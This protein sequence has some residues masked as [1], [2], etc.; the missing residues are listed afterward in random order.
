MFEVYCLDAQ[1]GEYAP[2]G[3]VDCLQRLPSTR[4][5]YSRQIDRVCTFNSLLCVCVLFKLCECLFF[6]QLGVLSFSKH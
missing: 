5:P 4:R 3:K 1:L 6:I 2:Q